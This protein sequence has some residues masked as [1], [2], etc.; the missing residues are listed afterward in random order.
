MCCS[1]RKCFREVNF[2]FI[3]KWRFMNIE[4]R[5]EILNKIKLFQMKGML[6]EQQVDVRKLD[7]TKKNFKEVEIKY[8]NLYQFF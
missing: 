2:V 1:K 5:G 6:N 4:G 3:I 8:L 7:E